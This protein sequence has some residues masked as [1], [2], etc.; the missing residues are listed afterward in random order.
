MYGIP[1]IAS[2]GQFA[3]M[4]KGKYTY[5]L[6]K[7]KANT[8]PS[9]PPAGKIQ[10]NVIWMENTLSA[11]NNYCPVDKIGNASYLV[12]SGGQKMFHMRL[13]GSLPRHPQSRQS[14][15]RKRGHHVC[16]QSPEA[17]VAVRK[18]YAA[19]WGDIPWAGSCFPFF[20]LRVPPRLLLAQGW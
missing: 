15:H 5:Q 4:R 1:G 16:S 2:T 6:K 14:P 3:L 7:N 10:R 9:M 12:V 18:R 19:C 8:T 17:L 20:C 11:G 13:G